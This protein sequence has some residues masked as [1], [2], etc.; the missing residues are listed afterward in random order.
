[1]NTEKYAKLANL[2]KKAYIFHEN[3]I[4]SVLFFKESDEIVKKQESCFTIMMNCKARTQS[5]WVFHLHW[6]AK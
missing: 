1:M 2:R 6:Y 4:K 5:E 3:S